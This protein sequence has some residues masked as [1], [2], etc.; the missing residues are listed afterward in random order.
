MKKY[1]FDTLNIVSVRL[2][3]LPENNPT[4]VELLPDFGDCA[5]SPSPMPVIDNLISKRTLDPDIN[6]I[7]EPEQ[8]ESKKG[9]RQDRE[10]ENDCG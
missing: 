4:S 5:C 9:D 1:F 7:A 3:S 8:F 2:S 6:C 10:E